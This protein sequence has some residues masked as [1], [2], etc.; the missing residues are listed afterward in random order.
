VRQ[1]AIDHLG[2]VEAHVDPD[3]WVTSRD[4]GPSLV[5]A[6]AHVELH[7]VARQ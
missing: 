7:L 3:P 6:G 1:L 2:Q 4:L 5:A